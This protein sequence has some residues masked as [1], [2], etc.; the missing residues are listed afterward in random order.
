MFHF[1]RISLCTIYLEKQKLCKV[2]ATCS[3]QKGSDRPVHYIEVI[4]L[5]I[6]NITMTDDDDGGGHYF[7]HF[8]NFR[9]LHFLCPMYSLDI[10]PYSARR[11]PFP[12]LWLEQVN[13]KT[14]WISGLCERFVCLDHSNWYLEY[15]VSIITTT[16]TACTCVL[17]L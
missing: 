7:I 5:Y 11:H 15:Q 1:T 14:A 9:P 3:E 13:P 16:L 2:R 4:V 12:V 17:M 8:S 10:S 6:K